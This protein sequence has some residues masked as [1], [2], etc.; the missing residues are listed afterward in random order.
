MALSEAAD[1]RKRQSFRVAFYWGFFGLFFVYLFS[2]RL[3]SL[4]RQEEGVDS[5]SEALNLYSQME[6]S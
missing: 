6:M 4:C 2:V 3:R 1:H 5:V